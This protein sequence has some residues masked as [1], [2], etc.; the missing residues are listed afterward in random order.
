MKV[1]VN[2]FDETKEKTIDQLCDEKF[3]KL[4][5]F[6]DYNLDRGETKYK[7]AIYH[8]L[9]EYFMS[10]TDKKA[11]KHDPIGI[12]NIYISYAKIYFIC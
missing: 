2:Y 10:E 12:I 3:G 8:Y 4:D 6:T 7:P 11:I 5:E 9:P 1:T